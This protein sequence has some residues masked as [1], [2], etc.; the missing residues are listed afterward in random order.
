MLLLI[1]NIKEDDGLRNASSAS[2]S[3][4]TTHETLPRDDKEDIEKSN[5]SLES[6]DTI[7]PEDTKNDDD[8]FDSEDD[9]P[10]TQNIQRP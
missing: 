1:W 9:I 8:E 4:K 3:V 10:L 5:E 6:S 2:L 7:P